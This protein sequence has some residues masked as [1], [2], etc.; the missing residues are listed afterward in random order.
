MFGVREQ[1]GYYIYHLR[2]ISLAFAS[3]GLRSIYFLWR[4]S[5]QGWRGKSVKSFA[6]PKMQVGSEGEFPPFFHSWPRVR[7][8][9]R[10]CEAIPYHPPSLFSS[11]HGL[12][13]CISKATRHEMVKAY[14][15]VR[16]RPVI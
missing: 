3:A 13:G 6:N 16:E 12:P 10:G 14:N 7:L 15:L 11:C 2:I 4:A 5:F 1:D 8:V 9:G